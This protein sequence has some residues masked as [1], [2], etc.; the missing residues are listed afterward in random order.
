MHFSGDWHAL[1]FNS[2]SV[3]G[4]IKNWGSRNP[5]QEVRIMVFA[6][7]AMVCA[8]VLFASSAMADDVQ[9]CRQRALDDYQRALT[10]CDVGP[11]PGNCVQNCVE[12][13]SNGTCRSYGADFC[14]RNPVCVERCT[15]RYSNGTC[16]SYGADA[17]QEGPYS[18]TERC[19]ERY[20]NGTCRTYGPDY[21]GYGTVSCAERC[22]ERYSNGTCRTY[23]EDSC[24]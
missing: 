11:G 19:T 22:I 13:Y 15:E 10:L 24:G 21:C 23:G 1:C 9:Q 18:C 8:V 4:F 16:R 5:Y 20:S 3:L 2:P 12:R 14:G 7:L 17:C 6:R